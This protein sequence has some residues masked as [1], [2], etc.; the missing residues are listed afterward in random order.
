MKS[1]I[2]GFLTPTHNTKGA[3]GNNGVGIPESKNQKK[4]KRRKIFKGKPGRK[5]VI[6]RPGKWVPAVINNHKGKAVRA[7]VWAYLDELK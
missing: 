3:F 4:D 2:Y 1:P 6:H 5:K 7:K